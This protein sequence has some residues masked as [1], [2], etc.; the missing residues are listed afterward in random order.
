L[1]A[2]FFVSSD[3]FDPVSD[4]FKRGKIIQAVADDGCLG[5]PEVGTDEG[6]EA[7]GTSRILQRDAWF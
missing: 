4:F 1:N 5:L 2:H 3:C 6:T 7:F